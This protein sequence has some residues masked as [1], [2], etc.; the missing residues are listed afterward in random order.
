M[1]TLKHEVFRLLSG[2]SRPSRYL[3]PLLGGA[4]RD[5]GKAEVFWT[6]LFPDVAESGWSHYGTELLHSALNGPEWCAA[7]RAFSPWPD[8][9]RA[10]RAAGVPLF[11]LPSYRPVREGDLLGITLQF[12][13]SYVTAVAAIDLAGLPIRAADRTDPLP[14]VVGGG[15]C[16]MNPEPLAPFFDLFVLGDGEEAAPRISEAVREWKRAGGGT[17]GELIDRLDRIE[18][19]YAPE[20]HP[21]RFDSRGRVEAVEGRTVRRAVVA[22]LEEHPPPERPAVPALQPVHDRVYAEIARGCGVGCR[23]CQAGMIYRPLRERPAASIAEWALRALRAT[24]H[25]DISLASLSTGDHGEIVEL[26]RDLDRR[27]AGCHTG[28]QLPSLR[29][30]TLT[31]ELIAEAARLG[32]TGFTLAPEAG[33]E[34]M[35][36]LINK[37]IERGDVVEAARLAVRGGWDLLK[38][39]FLI[40]LPTETEEDLDGIVSL[41]HEV[42]NV[43]R[44]GAGR[45]FRLNVSVST[46]VPK[47]HTPFQWERQDRPEETA[48]K[49]ER[50]RRALPRNRNLTVRFHDAPQTRVEGILA[51]GDRRLAPVIERLFREGVRFDEWSECFDP[52]AWE[53][54]FLACGVDADDYLRERDEAEP[55]PWDRIDAGPGREFLLRERRRSLEGKTTPVCDEGCRNCSLCGDELRVIRR[56]PESPAAAPPP[57]DEGASPETREAKHR[58]RFRFTKLAEWRFLSHLETGRAIRLALRRT[59][60]PIAYSLGFHPHARIAF[61]PAL[62]VGVGGRAEL[63]DVFLH[64]PFVPA[65]AERLLNAQLPHGLR[66]FHGREAPLRSRALDSIAYR[67]EYEARPPD[68][69]DLDRLERRVADFL[70]RSEVPV[71]RTTKGK[72]RVV[73]LR[74]GVLE[75]RL[76]RD[77]RALL[78]AV[79]SGLP[80]AELLLWWAEGDRDRVLRWTLTRT[81]LDPLEEGEKEID[82]APGIG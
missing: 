81:G 80:T 58:L 18:G 79:A 39:Y 66:F 33:T 15:P 6:L 4:F 24:G 46:L 32:K 70:S 13:L 60:L 78:F 44:E 56:R 52:R 37:G 72:T 21:V 67:M 77:E 69:E 54:A 51:R 27:L 29:V 36:R 14:L 10:M 50:I 28:I 26:V 41:I 82:P 12:E 30:A 73:D 48:R 55:L 25:E 59:D 3:P 22:D 57:P 61:G 76:D 64:E 62:P 65:D 74:P 71:E 63:M 47:P 5:P 40:G 43:G 1:R 45:R 2:V 20:R 17:K 9:E 53:G 68:G 19:V 16:A 7:E 49:Q 8:M 11:T 42:W 75:A 38:L 34:R 23:F 35:L 31:G